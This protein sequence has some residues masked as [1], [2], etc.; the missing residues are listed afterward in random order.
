MLDYAANGVRYW[1]VE[2]LRRMYEDQC[3]KDGRTPLEYL[4]TVVDPDVD[5]DE[6][7]NRVGEN[8]EIGRIRMVFVADL[9]PPA[10]QRIVEFL[11]EGMTRAQVYAVEIPQFRSSD[12]RRCVAPRLIG[13]TAWAT[14]RPGRDRDLPSFNEILASAPDHVQATSE[15]VRI[16][17]ESQGL[18][19]RL[20][21]TAM[22]YS[23]G[24][25]DVMWFAPR[26]GLLW[27][28]LNYLRDAD[29]GELADQFLADLQVFVPTRRLTKVQAGLPTEV[30]ATNWNDLFPVLERYLA[31][32]RAALAAD[33]ADLGAPS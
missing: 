25:D 33:D 15:R 13:A 24:S 10:L 1:P 8:L 16:W 21:R 20:T 22:L 12:G 9:V 29:R 19:C 18:R 6:F 17:A 26:D 2:H 28:Y 7:W 23:I 31:A 4:Q 27:L 11:N 30:L 3:R 5:P 32:T 14:S